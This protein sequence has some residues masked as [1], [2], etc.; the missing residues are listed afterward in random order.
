MAL[1]EEHPRKSY[2]GNHRNFIEQ[3]QYR[4]LWDNTQAQTVGQLELAHSSLSRTAKADEQRIVMARKAAMIPSRTKIALYTI[5]AKITVTTQIKPSQHH[6]PYSFPSTNGRKELSIKWIVD[7]A[8]PSPQ[9]PNNPLID[10]MSSSLS[11][12]L[13]DDS[14]LSPLPLPV[15]EPFQAPTTTSPLGNT[16]P[17]FPPYAYADPFPGNRLPPIPDFDNDGQ[18]ITHPLSPL[19]DPEQVAREQDVIRLVSTPSPRSTTAPTQDWSDGARAS[20][21]IWP[22]LPTFTPSPAPP[23][24][25]TLESPHVTPTPLLVVETRSCWE[26]SRPGHL[27]ANCPITRIRR[28]T[29]ITARNFIRDYDAYC[30]VVGLLR[31]RMNQVGEDYGYYRQLRDRIIDM[32]NWEGYPIRSIPTIDTT[33]PREPPAH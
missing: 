33:H 18:L 12:I 11:L 21:M 10:N 23:T 31:T 3:N 1:D 8:Q 22:P 17:S 2:E 19:Y 29:D 13:N 20:E 7:E 14:S 4:I 6:R 25:P 9:L 30:E 26:C 24:S 16:L 27:L 5:L 32:A 15:P 28:R